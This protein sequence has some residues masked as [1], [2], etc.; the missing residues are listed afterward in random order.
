VHSVLWERWGGEG[1]EEIGGAD[2]DVVG[3]GRCFRTF[4]LGCHGFGDAAIGVTGTVW[5]LMR[6]WCTVSRNH[7]SGTALGYPR[8]S[9]RTCWK[10]TQS[11]GKDCTHGVDSDGETTT[12]MI[13]NTGNGNAHRNAHGHASVHTLGAR[14]LQRLRG[15]AVSFVWWHL[16]RANHVGGLLELAGRMYVSLGSLC[17]KACSQSLLIWWS[18]CC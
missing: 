7:A 15:P 14:C 10:I 18:M 4:R 13:R 8:T 11:S 2:L 12:C 1:V 6:R 9:G 16:G 5:A 17:R 3:T